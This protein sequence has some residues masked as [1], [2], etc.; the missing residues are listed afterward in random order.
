MIYINFLM[1]TISF[2]VT[3][4]SFYNNEPCSQSIFS[5][6]D[7]DVPTHRAPSS[8]RKQDIRNTA[9]GNKLNVTLGFFNMGYKTLGHGKA[10]PGKS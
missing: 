1:T 10:S 5:I 3:H 8:T 9:L 7:R 2:N 4:S 6:L